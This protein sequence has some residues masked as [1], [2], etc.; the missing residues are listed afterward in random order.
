VAQAIEG[1]VPCRL[2][3]PPSNNRTDLNTYGRRP[4]ELARILI[5]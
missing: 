4:D 5:D 1:Y 2:G 3:G